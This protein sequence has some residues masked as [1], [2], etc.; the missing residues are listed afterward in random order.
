MDFN[1]V[2]QFQIGTIKIHA[3]AHTT[4]STLGSI[5]IVFISVINCFSTLLHKFTISV[6]QFITPTK[7]SS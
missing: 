4:A 3:L 7:S 1:G 2:I 5:C 6:K